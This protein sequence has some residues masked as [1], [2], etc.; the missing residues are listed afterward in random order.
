MFCRLVSIL[1]VRQRAEAGSTALACAWWDC[2]SLT[3][4]KLPVSADEPGIRLP[5]YTSA[6]ALVSDDM[7]MHPET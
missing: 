3:M 1:R 2:H 4:L 6:A 7:G 5:S